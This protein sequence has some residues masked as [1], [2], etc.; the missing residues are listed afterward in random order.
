MASESV[1][2]DFLNKASITSLKECGFL[3]MVSNK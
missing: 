1:F 2:T 3:D